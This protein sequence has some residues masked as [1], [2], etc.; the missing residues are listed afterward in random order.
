MKAI[1]SSTYDDK[2]LWFIPIA[3]YCW[4]RLGVDVICF[5]PDV[6]N[7]DHRKISLIGETLHKIN[8]KWHFEYFSSLEHKEATYAQCS[9]LYAAC[10]D[11]P[12]DEI[13][14]TS[15][16]DMGL[17]KI[18]PYTNSGFTIFGADLVPNDQLPM[19]FVSAPVKLWREDFCKGR[20]Y[21]KCLDDLVG[22]IECEHFRGNQWSL[23]QSELYRVIDVSEN[24]RNLI[25][26]AR[27]GTQ[28]ASNRVDR[29]DINWRSYVDDE[30]VDAH[31]WREGYKDGNF[32]NILELLTMKYPND[33]FTWLINYNEQ[34]KQL[35]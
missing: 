27:P 19:C 26:R 31:L 25:P 17:F 33:D 13:L 21:Q 14:C 23:D 22:V 5:L 1:I 35:L 2:Y 8:A 9:R 4:D 15:D 30:L 28:F 10:L 18:P 12:E 16:I 24:I 32:E 11:L 6:N 7:T 34:Y 3:T 29:D 20:T